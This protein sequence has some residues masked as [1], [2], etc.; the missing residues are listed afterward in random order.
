MYLVCGFAREV[1][2][3]GKFAKDAFLELA[4]LWGILLDEEAVHHEINA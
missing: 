3:R 1:H 4:A 2:A